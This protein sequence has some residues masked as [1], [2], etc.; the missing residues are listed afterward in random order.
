[1][2]GFCAFYSFS[3][4]CVLIVWQCTFCIELNLFI[5]F[6][7]ASKYI[8]FIIVP[9]HQQDTRYLFF[10]SFRKL[11]HLFHTRTRYNKATDSMTLTS[12]WIGRKRMRGHQC[13]RTLALVKKAL[14]HLWFQISS[15]QFKA[16]NYITQKIFNWQAKQIQRLSICFDNKELWIHTPKPRH[17][18]KR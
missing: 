12:M 13:A 5:G 6:F 16:V 15:R 3:F 4:V 7:Y 1:M 11:L 17:F 14:L 10:A 2:P 9:I 18:S 8:K